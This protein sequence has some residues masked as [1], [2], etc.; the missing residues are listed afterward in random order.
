M[1]KISRDV[2]ICLRWLKELHKDFGDQMEEHF[3]G[4]TKKS[5][6]DI[7]ITDLQS[8]LSVEFYREWENV[9]VPSEDSTA[10]WP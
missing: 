6:P 4:L 8:W 5:Q 1:G 9:D 3:L 10:E 2:K 7:D